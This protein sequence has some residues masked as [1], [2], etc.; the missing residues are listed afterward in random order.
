MQGLREA[1][2]CQGCQFRGQGEELTIQTGA[3]I[4]SP[5]CE[6]FDPKAY[7]IYGYQTLAQCRHQS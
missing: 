6:V 2:P 5:G 1:L 7:D 4:I 3:I